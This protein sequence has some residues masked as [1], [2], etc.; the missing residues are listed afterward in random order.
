MNTGGV[1]Y[2]NQTLAKSGAERAAHLDHS[3]VVVW[4][5]HTPTLP[6]DK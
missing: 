1:T 3:M 6:A 2:E 5:T 4:L